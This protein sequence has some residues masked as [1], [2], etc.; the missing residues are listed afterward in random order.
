MPTAGPANV[1]TTDTQT[2]QLTIAWDEVP[3]GSR[4]GNILEYV[5]DFNN[6]GEIIHSDTSN[7]QTTFYDL[8]PGTKYHFS[9][10]ASSSNG[11][12]PP[13][14]STFSTLPGKYVKSQFYQIPCEI[15]TRNKLF[16]IFFACFCLVLFFTNAF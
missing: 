13:V 9:I 4:R 6:M 12:G 15:E 11:R 3:C 7:R 2:R 1:R 16:F 5:Y 14:H 10:V 8:S